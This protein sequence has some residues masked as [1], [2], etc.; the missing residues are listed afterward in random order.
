MAF[1]GKPKVRDHLENL[2]LDGRV[3]L[4]WIINKQ[5]GSGWNGFIWQRIGTGSRLL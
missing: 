5:G 1:V 3:I 4:K 2:G